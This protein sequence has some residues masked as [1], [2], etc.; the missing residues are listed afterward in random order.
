MENLKKNRKIITQ[1]LV[2]DYMSTKNLSR[3]IIE[4]GRVRS[5]KWDRRHSSRSERAKTR[6]Y[7]AN[8]KKDPEFEEDSVKPKRQHVYKEF[9]DKLGPIYRWLRAQIGRKWDEVK[10]EIF[11]TFDTRNLAGQHIIYDHM[12]KSVE[13]V[14]DQTRYRYL[15]RPED[16]NTSYYKNDFYVDEEGI[17]QE[18][19][20]ISRRSRRQ[21]IHTKVVTDWLNGRLV[22]KV[23]NKM[24]WFVPVSFRGFLD[25]WKCVWGGYTDY[26]DVARRGWIE[27]YK[28]CYEPVYN[29]NKE[30]TEYKPFWRKP[31]YFGTKRIVARQSQEFSKDDLEMWK[32]IPNWC[33]EKI[34]DWSPN[35]PNPPKANQYS[36]Y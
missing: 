30:I 3:T 36:Y 13:E 8:L 34:L 25:E 31:I 12:L 20:Y 15:N 16:H 21:P 35:N 1:T 27:Y 29:T 9:D 2:G 19:K 22:G 7:L 23:G 18:K 14:E 24:Y 17:L 6:E 33:Q 11:Q 26:D 5:N 10:S 32:D 28:L 4:G